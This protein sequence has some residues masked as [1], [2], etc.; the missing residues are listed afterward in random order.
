MNRFGTWLSQFCTFQ[1]VLIT[2]LVVLEIVSVGVLFFDGVEYWVSDLVGGTTTNKILKFLEIGMGGILIVLLLSWKSAMNPF[3]KIKENLFSIFQ[4]VLIGV[5]ILLVVV[6]VVVMYFEPEWIF[7]GLGLGVSGAENQQEVSGSKNPKHEAL[8]FLGISMGG[9]L[10]ALQALMSYKRAKAM[11]ETVSHTEQGLRQERLKN[12]IE[13]LGNEKESLRWGG[14]YEL[15]HLAKDSKELRQTALDMLCLHIRQTTSETI[16]RV[17]H[18]SKPS[19]EVQSILRLIFVQEHEVFKGLRI[20]LQGSWLNGANLRKARLQG[21]VLT[22]AH[23]QCADLRDACLQ[24]ADLKESHLEKA[25]LCDACLQCADLERAHLQGAFLREAHLQGARLRSVRLQCADLGRARLQGAELDGAHLQE[26]NLTMAYLQGTLLIEAHLQCAVLRGTCLQ[27]ADLRRARLQCAILD[28]VHLQGAD[29]HGTRLQGVGIGNSHSMSFR[30]RIWNQIGK[31][32]DLSSAIFAGG[33]T[34]EYVESL[35]E[36]LSEEKA[37]DL[38]ERLEPHIDK[39]ASNELPE[40]HKVITEAYTKEEA[41]QWIAEYE[42][43]S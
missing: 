3:S 19:E 35:A 41:E 29:L 43:D 27:C 26:A 8:K 6:F 1:V 16:Y 28:E 23:L 34:K 40:N 21:A 9:I 4:T 14:A 31:E 42:K 7:D 33:L 15:F 13:H 24:C 25:K 12:A 10:I 37:N 11:E 2:L 18:K 22:G 32:S 38:R 20:E 36:G 39:P 5:L 17:A 30:N